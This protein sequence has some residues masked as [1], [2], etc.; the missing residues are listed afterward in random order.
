MLC[1]K[2]NTLNKTTLINREE[3]NVDSAPESIDFGT[4]ILPT[5]PIAYKKAIR[6]MIYDIIP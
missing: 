4:K 6:K 2:A 3:N 5:K 1:C